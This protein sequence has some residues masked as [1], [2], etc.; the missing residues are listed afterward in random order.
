MENIFCM[1][2]G[3][4]F[5][6]SDKNCQYCGRPKNIASEEKNSIEVPDNIVYFDFN[7]QAYPPNPDNIVA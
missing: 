4:I 1:Y 5:S 3:H 6:P 7:K 2:C